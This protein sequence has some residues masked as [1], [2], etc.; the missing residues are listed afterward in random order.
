MSIHHL[1]HSC[2][3]SHPIVIYCTTTCNLA[4]LTLHLNL[5]RPRRVLS[6]AFPRC[7]LE[8]LCEERIRFVPVQG[9]GVLPVWMLCWPITDQHGQAQRGTAATALP[10]SVRHYLCITQLH[11][12]DLH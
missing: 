7:Q 2:R 5:D 11:T 9:A 4:I 8:G 10:V 12:W 3:I 6:G 1:H